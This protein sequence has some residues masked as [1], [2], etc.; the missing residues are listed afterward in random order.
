M[1]PPLLLLLVILAAVA[2]LI[3]VYGKG[4]LW[5]SVAFLVAI[6]VLQ[7]WPR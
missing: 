6:E 7:V 1:I 2:L 3:H 5:V 4:P